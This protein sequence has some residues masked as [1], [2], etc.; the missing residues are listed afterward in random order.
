M[1]LYKQI[2]G[3]SFP[4]STGWSFTL[5][6]N[7][8]TSI[9]AANSTLVAAIGDLW[10][11]IAGLVA[12]DVSATLATTVELDPATGKQTGK[13]ETSVAHPGT[14]ASASVSAQVSVGVSL[15]TATPTRAGRGRMYLLPF[16]TN[17]FAAGRLTT[18]AQ[19][20]TVGG[21][22]G[23]LDA[24]TSGSLTPVIYSRTAHTTLTVVSFDIGDVPDTQRRR[25]NKMIENRTSSPV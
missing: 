18:A 17:A 20:A 15:R 24:M 21:V 9:T 12:A 14:S 13:Y 16:A 3:G 2:V 11:G 10:D 5:H 8:S 7:G 4:T 22:R 19:T 6:C 25:R 1:A 23:F